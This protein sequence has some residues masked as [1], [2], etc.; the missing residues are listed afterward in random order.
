MGE[1]YINGNSTATVITTTLTW[2][3]FNVACTLNTSENFDMPATGRLRYTGAQTAHFH[4]GATISL[5]GAGSND[6]MSAVLYKNGTVNGNDE[7]TAGTALVAGIVT[8]KL[9]ASGDVGST[10]IHVMVSLAQ[11]DYIELAIQNESGTGNI[12][13]EDM[14]IFGMAVS[15]ALTDDIANAK[16]VLNSV[17]D[18]NQAYGLM[19]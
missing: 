3:K 2:T 8:R 13:I 11:N 4:L 15:P 19:Q 12:T 7:F 14:N 16:Q 17:I 5:S 1:M 18:D 6:V 10:A 9:G